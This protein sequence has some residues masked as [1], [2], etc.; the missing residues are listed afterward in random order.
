MNNRC[1]E[2]SYFVKNECYVNPPCTITNTDGKEIS[3]R[4]R[5][6]EHDRACGKFHGRVPKVLQENDKNQ[7]KS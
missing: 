5:V 1:G 3:I 4:P 7:I 6:F 2:C